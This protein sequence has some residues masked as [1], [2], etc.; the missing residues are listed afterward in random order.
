MSIQDEL[1][2]FIRAI[3]GSHTLGAAEIAD[4]IFGRY[5]VLELPEPTEMH[6]DGEVVFSDGSDEG[7]V[8]VTPGDGVVYS[9]NW[10]WTSEQAYTVGLNW[11]AAAEASREGRYE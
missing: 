9:H 11:I 5:T 6:N 2:N 8:N 3:D 1:A 10:E 7:T 4:A